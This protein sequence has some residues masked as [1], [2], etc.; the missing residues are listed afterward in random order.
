MLA[1][2][3]QQS[4]TISQVRTVIGARQSGQAHIRASPAN[5]SEP[6]RR[7]ATSSPASSCNVGSLV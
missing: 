3:F 6:A 1:P 4:A 7:P 5:Q 2:Q